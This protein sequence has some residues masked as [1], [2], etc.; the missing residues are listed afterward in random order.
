MSGLFSLV[1][2]IQAKSGEHNNTFFMSSYQ[3][4]QHV[5]K[6]VIS[7]KELQGVITFPEAP[8]SSSAIT[9]IKCTQIQGQPI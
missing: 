7:A 2:F 3:L 4:Q 1:Q 8:S 5:Q 6:E 9:G